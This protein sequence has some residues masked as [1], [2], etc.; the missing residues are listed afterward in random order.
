VKYLDDSI[1]FVVKVGSQYLVKLFEQSEII[2]SRDKYKA[3]EYHCKDCANGAIEILRQNGFVSSDF[4]VIR[5][6]R[7]ENVACFPN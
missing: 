2:F 7:K 6:R 4:K 3:R 1:T 5:R